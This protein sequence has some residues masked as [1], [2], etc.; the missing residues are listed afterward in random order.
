MED[1]YDTCVAR[2]YSDFEYLQKQLIENYGGC[3][4]P[5]LPEKNFWANVNMEGEE[6]I[7]NRVLALEKYIKSLLAHDRLR[8]TEELS[9]FLFSD[10][11]KFS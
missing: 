1:T 10:E 5:I 6:Y 7:K 2:R 9:H 8:S 11:A 3:I 4:I